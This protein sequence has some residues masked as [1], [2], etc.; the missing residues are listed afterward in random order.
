VIFAEP[1]L[2]VATG[3]TGVNIAGSVV[4][5][6]SNVVAVAKSIPQGGGGGSGGITGPETLPG[7]IPLNLPGTLKL[8][9]NILIF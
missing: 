1:D 9:P 4:Q 8:F 7:L 2:P 6:L 3:T 5:P